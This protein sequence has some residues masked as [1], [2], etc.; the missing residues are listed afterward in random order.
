M[1]RRQFFALAA[2]SSQ[3]RVSA[4]GVTALVGGRL[5]DGTGAPPIPDSVVVISD[6]SIRAAGPRANVKVPPAARVIDIEGRTVLP[7]FVDLHFHYSPRTAEAT[8]PSRFLLN[9]VTTV[10]DMGNWIEH[11][12]QAVEKMQA[13]GLPVPRFLQTGPHLDGS[14]PA[15]PNDAIVILDQ[16]DAERE[17]RKLLEKGATSI[18]VYFR[19]PLTLMKTVLD[20]AHAQKVHV[21]GHLEIVDVREAIKIGLDGVEHTPS[22]GIA[23]IPPPEAEAY[24][25]A[26]LRSN[27]ARRS[28]RYA[29]WEKIDV[30]SRAARELIQLMISRGVYLSPTIA[31]FETKGEKQPQSLR[32]MAA[33]TAAFRRAGGRLV[34]GSHGSVPNAELGWAF[35]RE[36]ETFVEAGLSPAEALVAATSAGAAALRLENVGVIRPGA[37]ADLQVV[38][39]DPLT[40]IRDTRRIEMVVHEG[41]VLRRD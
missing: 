37:I 40:N 24:R 39:G 14:N 3:Y 2:A 32:N 5:F 17:T 18:K 33:F 4:P 30:D 31:V 41:A 26:I 21:T 11:N 13:S 1:N 28:G 38:G 12:R 25:Q 15:Y 19:L 10:R 35:H 36:L 23:L 29:M 22:V 7:G 8:L 9:G 34:V 16:M 27:D 20:T 6:G